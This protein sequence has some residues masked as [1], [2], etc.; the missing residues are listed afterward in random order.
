[1]FVSAQAASNCKGGLQSTESSWSQQKRVPYQ[2]MVTLCWVNVV[3][4][5]T[6][7][8]PKVNSKLDKECLCLGVH[9]YTDGQ[10]AQNI[11]PLAPTIHT[12]TRLT[13]LCPGLPGWVGT[14]KIKQI[15]ILLKQETVSGSGISWAICKCAPRSRQITM[16]APHCSV[17]YRPDALPAAQPTVSKHW[18]HN[19]YMYIKYVYQIHIQVK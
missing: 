17:F 15:W 13:A 6:R 16:P 9:T 18:R 10:T 19:K 2:T 5:Y 12:H 4:K 3:E 14:R 1:M 7:K 8:K 11:M